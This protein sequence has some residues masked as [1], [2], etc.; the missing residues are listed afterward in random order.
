MTRLLVAS[1]GGHLSELV[2]LAPR[3]APSVEDELWLTFDSCQSRSL[4]AG[5]R[6]RFIRE[7]PPRDWRGVL[8]NARVA[9]RLLAEMD[10]EMVVS[11]GAG[12]ALSFLPLA[13]ARGIPAHYI[14]CA[15]RT[16]GPSLTG[17]I[18]ER[19]G[20]VQLYTQHREL[21]SPR[22]RY[23]GSAFE[24]YEAVTDQQPA[25]LRTVLVTTGTLDFSFGRLYDR[26]K[27][28]LPSGVRVVVQAGPDSARLDWPGATVSSTLAPEALGSLMRD[29]DIVVAHAGIGSALM[30]FEAGKSPIL[31][32]R[33][34]CHGEHV[35]EHQEQIARK[36]ADAGLAVTAEASAVGPE[37]FSQALARRVERARAQRRFS[38]A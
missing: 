8:A 3:L 5:R 18:L 20:A 9:R 25:S 35:D 37:H 16:T 36:F 4:L 23:A 24:S 13:V 29:A 2:L 30:A 21:K 12:V 6:V 38:L 31:V 17:R 34:R 26:L 22:W 28:V 1:T 10:V 33:R 15:A 19:V 7:T 11:N 27:A 14:E 32:P